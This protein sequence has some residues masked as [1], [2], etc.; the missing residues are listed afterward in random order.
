MA[1]RLLAYLIGI[2]FTIA[3]LTVAVAWTNLSNSLD[4]AR[5]YL[6]ASQEYN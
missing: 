3:L 2:T 6:E 4:E 5:E 1:T